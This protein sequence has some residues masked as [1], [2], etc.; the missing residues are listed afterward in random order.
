MAAVLAGGPGA[1]ACHRL[2]GAIWDVIT[3]NGRPSVTVP[4]WRPSTREIRFHTRSLPADEVTTH[5]EIPVTTVP[6]TLLDLATVLNRPR[7]LNAINEAE[8]RQLGDALSLPALIDRHRGERGVAIL[9]SVLADAGYG[10]SDRE[11]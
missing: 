9:R 3:W 11:L 10:V 4:S 1:F 8:E 5:S 2:A 7:L 6:R